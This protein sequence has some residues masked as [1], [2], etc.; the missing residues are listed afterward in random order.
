[1]HTLRSADSNT[2][3]TNLKINNIFLNFLT[4]A[5]LVLSLTFGG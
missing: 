4:L 2:C 3:A 5:L 1:M